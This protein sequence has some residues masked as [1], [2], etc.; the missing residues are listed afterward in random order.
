MPACDTC[1]GT[2]FEIVQKDGRDFARPCRCKQPGSSSSL[3][4]DELL[5]RSR[6]PP[7]YRHCTLGNFAPIDRPHRAALEKVMAFC[8]KFASV[9]SEDGLGLLFTGD[10]GVGK[11]HLAIATLH[12]LVSTKGVR[13]AFWDFH[14]LM[15]EIKRSYDPETKTTEVQVLDPVVEI[16][17]LLLDDLGAWKITD[18]MNDTLFYILNSRYLA[19]RPTIV[20]TNLQD[21]SLQEAQ[22]ADQLVRRE[23]LVDRIGN[24][25]RS[26]LAEM[27]LEISLHG[28]DFR[29]HQQK[30]NRHKVLGTSTVDED[31]KPRPTPPPPRRPRFGG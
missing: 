1:D 29:E 4:D 26:R 9:G 5:I 11:T 6:I 28:A 14:E 16:D 23:F 15:R 24:R 20:T 19:Q 2:G 3:T 8:A 22:K 10:N 31:S 18:W 27:C 7:R 13:G 30:A 21:V 17:L 25:L 12:E